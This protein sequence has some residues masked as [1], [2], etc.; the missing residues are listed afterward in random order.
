M[1]PGTA[2]AQAGHVNLPSPSFSTLSSLERCA[3]KL[4]LSC[5]HDFEEQ[6]LRMRS[7]NESASE[8]PVM[9]PECKRLRYHA[10]I[11]ARILASVVCPHARTIAL[12]TLS[13]PACGRTLFL[14]SI[15]PDDG[16]AAESM[17]GPCNHVLKPRFQHLPPLV[18]SDPFR[19]STI[20][21]MVT[22]Q[23]GTVVGAK[24][25]A[26]PQTLASTLAVDDRYLVLIPNCG[27]VFILCGHVWSDSLPPTG[28]THVGSHALRAPSYTP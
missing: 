10:P 19:I 27:S 15:W 25:E 14:H 26:N 6:E 20:L 4:T 17:Y 7:S 22:S 8:L 9:P 1:T 3:Q 11:R 28:Y 5:S 21:S 23:P 18:L 13:M 16:D 2:A 24:W 12:E